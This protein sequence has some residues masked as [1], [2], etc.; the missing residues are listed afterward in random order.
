MEKRSKGREVI[1]EAQK[2]L[3]QGLSHLNVHQNRLVETHCHVTPGLPFR[4]SGAREFACLTHF[5]LLWMTWSGDPILRTPRRRQKSRGRECKG[6]FT[7]SSNEH[8]L[9][10]YYGSGTGLGARDAEDGKRDWC[11]RSGRLPMSRVRRVLSH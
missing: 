1:S 10:T 2:G 11:P 6:S 4:V 3:E 9:S 5:P 8:L 7:S